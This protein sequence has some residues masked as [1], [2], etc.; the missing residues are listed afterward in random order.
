VSSRLA[1]F[2]WYYLVVTAASLA[3]LVRMLR[4]GPQVTWTAVEGTR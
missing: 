4:E 2:A 1:A 3:G